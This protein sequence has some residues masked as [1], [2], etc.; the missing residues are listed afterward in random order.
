MCSH[1][2]TNDQQSWLDQYC[3]RT[4]Q[5]RSEVIR[6]GIDML[7][8]RDSVNQR[9]IAREQAQEQIEASQYA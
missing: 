1:R 9:R 8:T 4:S 3:A 2:L 6:Q 7:Q 5:T